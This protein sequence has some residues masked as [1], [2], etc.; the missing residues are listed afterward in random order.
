MLHGL[1]GSKKNW[2]SIGKALAASGRRVN[3]MYIRGLCDIS[4]IHVLLWD[5]KSI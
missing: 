1:F 5:I 2:E 4:M 3:I